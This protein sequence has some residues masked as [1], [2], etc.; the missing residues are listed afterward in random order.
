MDGK[1]LAACGKCWCEGPGG[2]CGGGCGQVGRR[3]E[4]DEGALGATKRG[5]EDQSP[6]GFEATFEVQGSMGEENR[7]MGRAALV[8]RLVQRS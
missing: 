4:E 7:P 8:G 5:V 3:D 6:L 1:R 2:G